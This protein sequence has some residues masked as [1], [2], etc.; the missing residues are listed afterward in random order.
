MIFYLIFPLFINCLKFSLCRFIKSWP[1]NLTVETLTLKGLWSTAGIQ[2]FCSII[3]FP[4]K[5]LTLDNLLSRHIYAVVESL[6]SEILELCLYKCNVYNP[7]KKTLEALNLYRVLAACPTLESIKLACYGP[8]ESNPTYN[9][10][11][12]N[13]AN[14][15]E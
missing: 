11:A 2:R 9:I 10:T 14:I 3:T 5:G 13:F 6:G 15:K 4:L 8:I 1:S 7:K 12:R